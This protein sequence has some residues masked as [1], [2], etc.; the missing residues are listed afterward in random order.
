MD[1]FFLKK[2]LGTLLMPLNI[3]VI[4]LLLSIYLYKKK[5]K[6]SFHCLVT[7]TTLLILF[8]LPIVSK[9]LMAPL[10]NNFTAYSTIKK[11]IDYIIVLGGYHLSNE[12]LPATIE[13][14]S[15]SLER[16]VEAIRIANLHPE[17]TIIMSGGKAD[18]P[19]SNADKMKEAAILLGMK[20]ARIITESRPRDT[21]EEAKLIA[22]IVK[23]KTTI[24][25]T[26]ADHM[27]RSVNYFKAQGIDVV[28]APASFWVKGND[29]N[30]HFEVY[31][32]TPSS[33]ALHQTTTFWYEVLGLSWQ[34]LKDLFNK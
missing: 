7:S 9:S 12:E 20:E 11:K 14:A 33:R 10:E 22:P 19:E 17:A 21:Q 5:H 32:I 34:W 30:D 26:N 24:L 13:L 6:Y 1:L 27:L 15:Y 31:S 4:L 23:N 3:V 25:V 16:L 8:S 28:P 2:I 18:N 29:K